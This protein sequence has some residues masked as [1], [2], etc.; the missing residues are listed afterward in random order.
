[1][2]PLTIE[3]EVINCAKRWAWH[4]GKAGG[5]YYDSAAEKVMT[6]NKTTR[7]LLAAVSKLNANTE[8]SVLCNQ[9][10]EKECYNK[11][12][13]RCKTCEYQS[14]CLCTRIDRPYTE[15]KQDEINISP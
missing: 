2:E 4:Y 14:L 1:M 12:G 6:Q 7:D 8:E 10:P 11:D 9:V 5:K 15:N 3:Q 13:S